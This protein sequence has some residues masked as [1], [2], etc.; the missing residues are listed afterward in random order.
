MMAGRILDAGLSLLDR[1]IVDA[2]GR[3]AGKVDDL[4]LRIPE[5]GGPP[6]VTA[7]LSGPGALARRVGGRV[8]AWVESVHRRLHPKEMPGPARID[9]GVVKRIASSVDISISKRDLD[10]NLFEAWARDR[11]ISKIPGASHESV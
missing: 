4:E 6:V 9:F 3:F 1:Q 7:I 10:T 8:G 5:D 11:V 2:D